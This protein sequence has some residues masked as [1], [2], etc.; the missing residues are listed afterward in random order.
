VAATESGAGSIRATSRSATSA[1]YAGAA[2]VGGRPATRSATGRVPEQ[3]EQAQAAQRELVRPVRVV[4][5]ECQRLHLGQCDHEPIDRVRELLLGHRLAR[6]AGQRQRAAPREARVEPAVVAT[7]QLRGGAREQNAHGGQRHVRLLLVGQRGEHPQTGG[8]AGVV[9]AAEQ[10][11]LPAPR[12]TLDQ[13]RASV[14]GLADA[15]Q[16]SSSRNRAAPAREA[17]LEAVHQALAGPSSPADGRITRQGNST[18]RIVDVVA[19]L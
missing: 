2:P 19:V 7:E 17:A 18:V 11:G 12:F 6:L 4:D 13:D 8:R 14:A 16:R 15:L 3:R 9:H 1:R 10:G 5:H